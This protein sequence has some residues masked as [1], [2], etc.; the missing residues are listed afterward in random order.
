MEKNIFEGAKFGDKFV[1]KDA[2]ILIYH[3]CNALPEYKDPIY[4]FIEEFNSDII[5][6]DKSGKCLN[7][8]QYGQDYDIVSRYQD[9][10]TVQNPCDACRWKER[11]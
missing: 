5:I 3:C 6:C 4:Q 8:P 7:M 1:T 11:P 10:I 2:R 9:P